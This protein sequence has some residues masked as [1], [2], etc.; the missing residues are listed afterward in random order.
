[1]AARRR[2]RDTEVTHLSFKCLNRLLGAVSHS[3]VMLVF[4][5][6]G[7]Q[8]ESSLPLRTEEWQDPGVKAALVF[9]K[10]IKM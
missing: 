2:L 4:G 1:M 8:H 10:A 5:G 3:E 7:L 9:M 6:A